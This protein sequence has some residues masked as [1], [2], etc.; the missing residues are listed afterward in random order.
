MTSGRSDSIA[1]V[2][3]IRDTVAATLQ[4]LHA[5]EMAA[6]V[7]TDATQYAGADG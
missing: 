5:A 3:D 6:H 7:R 1:R 4:M 2:V